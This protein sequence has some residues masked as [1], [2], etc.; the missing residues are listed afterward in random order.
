MRKADCRKMQKIPVTPK[1]KS[2]AA[3]KSDQMTYYN[4]PCEGLYRFYLRAI[5]EGNKVKISLFDAKWLN[6]NNNTSKY[7]IFIDTE[8]L[9]YITLEKDK[10]GNEKK[11]R[12]ATL[13]YLVDYYDYRNYEQIAWSN[14]DTDRKLRNALKITDNSMQY[15][16]TGES[17]R[18]INKYQQSILDARMKKKEQAEYEEWD[19]DMK[20]IKA[21]PKN[22]NEWIRLHAIKEHY[23]FYNYSKKI[24][25]GFCS[26]CGKCVSP[27]CAALPCHLPVP[28]QPDTAPCGCR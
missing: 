11:W 10:N 18:I 27:H 2:L 26:H 22:F 13:S 16:V 5:V 3:K 25:K 28:G 14:I 6:E 15:R 12:S 21:T 8:E 23:M 17:Y 19:R 24:T 9:K 20:P 4:T 1:I 7:D